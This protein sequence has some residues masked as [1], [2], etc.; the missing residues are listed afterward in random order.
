MGGG[1]G[2]T[3]CRRSGFGRLQPPTFNP[4]P[5]RRGPRRGIQ[6][7]AAAANRTRATPAMSGVRLSRSH[8]AFGSTNSLG[9][10]PP[11][12]PVGYSTARTG[13][14]SGSAG[15]VSPGIG[16]PSGNP[17][18]ASSGGASSGG[19]TPAAGRGQCTL[20]EFVFR[21]VAPPTRAVALRGDWADWEPIPMAV[22]VEAG[23]E[24]GGALLPAAPT[25]LSPGGAVDL[26]AAGAAA[27]S[28][29]TYPD[30][31]GGGGVAGSDGAEAPTYW[32]VVTRVPVGYVEFVFTVEGAVVVS[33]QHPLTHDGGANFR[34]IRGPGAGASARHWRGSSVKGRARG[35]AAVLVA[36]VSGGGSGGGGACGAV[37]CGWGGGG[38]AD[39]S[40]PLASL[41]AAKGALASWLAD[42]SI[43]DRDRVT[44]SGSG[45]GSGGSSGK[46]SPQRPLLPYGVGDVKDGW[47]GSRGPLD[48]LTT[49]SRPKLFA[50]AVVVY[51]VCHLLGRT[52]AT[53]P[54]GLPFF[55]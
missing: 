47:D 55:S 15:V 42:S 35:A 16:G 45:S 44:A 51:V 21:L 4:T 30:A 29:D 19:S 14:L 11:D 34:Y 52:L 40:S 12:A 28:A 3:W 5:C 48:V 24:G 41:V 10:L 46:P 53:S 25:C 22:M 33:P 13:Q 43:G 50:S 2:Q 6:T 18:P 23:G 27:P 9:G 31:A 8:G 26:T 32:V 39:L 38:A 36:A 7:P 37:E 1:A 49:A 17:S 54:R 20:A